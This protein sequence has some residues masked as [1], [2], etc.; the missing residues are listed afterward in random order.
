MFSSATHISTFFLLFPVDLKSKLEI[1]RQMFEQ[2]D[3]R[4]IFLRRQCATF[5]ESQQSSEI[6]S[7]GSIKNSGVLSRGLSYIIEAHFRVT[8]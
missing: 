4:I 5:T 1:G 2:E 7:A 3:K 6:R 8:E